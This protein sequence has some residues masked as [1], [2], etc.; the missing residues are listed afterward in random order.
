MD[1]GAA[2]AENVDKMN[3]ALIKELKGISDP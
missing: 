3:T 2:E 1:P